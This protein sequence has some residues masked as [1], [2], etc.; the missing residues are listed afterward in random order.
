M[1]ENKR[2]AMSSE[3]QATGYTVGEK[4]CPTLPEEGLPAKITI[5]G[6]FLRYNNEVLLKIV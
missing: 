3:L 4:I 6:Y 2:K 1:R 5:E